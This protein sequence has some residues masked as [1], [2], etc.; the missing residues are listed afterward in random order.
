MPGVGLGP[1]RGVAHGKH[2]HR[3][4]VLRQL[5]NPA[6][7]PGV[8]ARSHTLCTPSSSA[9]A[10]NI[11]TENLVLMFFVGLNQ[12]F[13]DIFRAEIK[14]Y[15]FLQTGVAQNRINVRLQPDFQMILK[16]RD[17][18]DEQLQVVPLQLVLFLNGAEDVDGGL[19]CAVQ[20]NDAIAI[21]DSDQVS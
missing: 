11:D 20:L 15:G 3:N 8:K 14:I 21:R 9:F 2:H 17:P 19:G 12:R 5:E 6:N 7:R 18:V 13:F 4:D 1:L 16:D 10:D